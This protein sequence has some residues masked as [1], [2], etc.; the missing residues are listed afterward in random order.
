MPQSLSL[1][2]PR[3]RLLWNP[4]APGAKLKSQITDDRH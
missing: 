2:H 1:R 3:V 4:G